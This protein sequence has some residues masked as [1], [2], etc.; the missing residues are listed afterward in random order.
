MY[1]HFKTLFT[2]ESGS[3]GAMNKSEVKILKTSTFLM[4]SLQMNVMSS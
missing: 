3:S 1:S 4:L 2:R